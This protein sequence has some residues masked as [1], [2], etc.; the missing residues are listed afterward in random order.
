MSQQLRIVMV[1]RG[2]DAERLDLLTGHLTRE[3][4][5]LDDV[6]VDPARVEPPHGARAG[7]A[8]QVGS[9]V[10][11]MLSSASLPQLLTAVRGWLGRGTTTTAGAA[12][13]VRLELDGD[14]LELGHATPEEQDRL[15]ELFVRSHQTSAGS[16]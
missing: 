12:R 10:V 13:S 1:E 4:R 6:T 3:L 5:E 7:E 2:A 8:L 9:L 14:A 11:T 16:T 15:V